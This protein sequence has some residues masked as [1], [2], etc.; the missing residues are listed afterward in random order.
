MISLVIPFYS[1]GARL[2]NTLQILKEAQARYGISQ[3]LLG[4]N[5]P[6][7]STE[8]TQQLNTWIWPGVELT[9]NDNRGV[10]AGCKPAIQ[11]ATGKYILITGSDL[12]FGFTDLD[13]ILFALKENPNLKIAIGSKGHRD[14]RIMGS[15]WARNLMS[16]FFWVFRKL[17]VFWN[18]PKDTQGSIFMETELAKATSAQCYIDNYLYTMELVTRAQKKGH[19]VLEVPV[20]CDMGGGGASSVS[21]IRDS[22]ASLKEMLIFSLK[23]RGGH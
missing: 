13:N 5:G 6:P 12:P 17:I 7:M 1:D 20:Q 14:S 10:G 16:N 15:S 9:H 11:L 21:V 4:H 22:L 18:T 23:L 3:I 8:Q 2:K 19:G